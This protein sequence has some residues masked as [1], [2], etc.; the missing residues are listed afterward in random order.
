[1]QGAASVTG[2]LLSKR[3]VEKFGQRME[4]TARAAGV[5]PAVVYLPADPKA[6][7]SPDECAAI[8]VACYTRDIRVNGYYESYSAALLG[9]KNLK[10]LHLASAGVDQHPFVPAL[11]ERGVRITTSTGSN[12]EPVAQTAITGL[13]MLARKFPFWLDAQRR[14]AWERTHGIKSPPADI[15]GQTVLIVGLGTIG[16]LIAGFCQALGMQVIGVRR[17]PRQND[18]IVAEIHPP[19]RLLELLPRCAWLVLACPYTPETHHMVHAEAIAALPRGACIINIARGSIVDEPAMTA[20]LRSGQLGGAYLDVVEEEPLAAESPLW[21]MPNV[22]LTPHIASVSSG[23]ES[24]ASEMFFANL[25]KLVRGA[26]LSH[27]YLG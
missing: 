9:A 19:A 2:I 27:E 15:R 10:W 21:D 14:H 5:S 22:I 4:K 1:V 8:E 16:T 12:S 20:A 25:E 17:T 26:P 23:N 13:L 18:D 24:R 11:L 6:R 3:F 7:L